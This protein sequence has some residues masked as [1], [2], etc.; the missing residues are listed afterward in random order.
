MWDETAV[1]VVPTV[2]CS[3]RLCRRGLYH[4]PSHFPSGTAHFYRVTPAPMNTVCTCIESH[5]SSAT[6]DH[7]AANLYIYIYECTFC[8]SVL[9][10]AV[11]EPHWIT[12][13]Q[14]VLYIVHACVLLLLCAAWDSTRLV[15]AHQVHRLL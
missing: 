3:P 9:S 11:C 6:A 8:F 12:P 7:T 4:S 15:T 2:T 14:R 1:R 10:F 13:L 5:V